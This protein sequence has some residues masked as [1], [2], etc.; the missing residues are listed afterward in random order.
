VDLFVAA[1][2]LFTIV[3][4]TGVGVRIILRSRKDDSLPE[5][6]VGVALVAFCGVTQPLSVVRVALEGQ[7]PPAANSLLQVISSF[8]AAFATLCL[9]LFTWRV[10]RPHAPWAALL[11]TGGSALG[12]W[13]GAGAATLAFYDSSF[14]PSLTGRW[15]ALSALSYAVCFAWAGAESFAYRARLRRRQRLGLADPLLVNRFLLWASACTASFAIDVVL[16]ICAWRGVDFAH[17]LNMRLLVSASSLVQA[18]AWY[19]GFT[20]PAWYVRWI[21]GA[22]AGVVWCHGGPGGGPPPPPP[23]PA[24]NSP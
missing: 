16:M 23:P 5:L 6:A 19:L 18:I 7:I 2:T 4:G 20:A 12:L 22:G 8:A 14:Q 9:Y 3:V 15:V 1:A 11:F 17:D 13:A 24:T 21:G 10:F